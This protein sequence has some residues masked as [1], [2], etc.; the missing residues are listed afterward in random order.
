MYFTVLFSDSV[1]LSM[2]TAVIPCAMFLPSELSSFR[3]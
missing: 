3:P 2:I 1:L